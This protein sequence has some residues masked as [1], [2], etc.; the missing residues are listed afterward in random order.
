M[1]FH[2]KTLPQKPMKQATVHA[3]TTHITVQ[4]IYRV[5]TIPTSF[6][7]HPPNPY[8]TPYSTAYPML[9]NTYNYHHHQ[10]R[11][12]VSIQQY[13]YPQSLHTSQNIT[14]H[15][16]TNPN[17]NGNTTL[18]KMHFALHSQAQ[19]KQNNSSLHHTATNMHY[20]Q[21]TSTAIQH[22][23]LHYFLNT[24]T[25]P[26]LQ[27]THTQKSHNTLTKLHN[28]QPRTTKPY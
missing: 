11:H 3:Q 25:R 8:R 12:L 27:K 15:T 16:T 26:P 23:W 4:C 19:T 7:P 14:P 24:P 28:T 17:F 9:L 21:P 22:S 6:Q 5:A 13:P 20:K 10:P 18:S 2:H 1:H